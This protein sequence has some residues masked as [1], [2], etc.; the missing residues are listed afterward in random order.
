MAS[1]RK[2]APANAETSTW[3]KRRRDDEPTRR[4]TVWLPVDVLRALRHA[5]ADWDTSVSGAIERLARERL[6]HYIDG[7]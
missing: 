6:G 1:K 4:V 3:R 5:A 2:P 7:K